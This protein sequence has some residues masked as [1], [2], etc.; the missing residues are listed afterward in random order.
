[1]SDNKIIFS[2][3]Q[4]EVMRLYQDE[5][6]KEIFNRGYEQGKKDA[7]NKFINKFCTCNENPLD[8]PI[9]IF[10]NFKKKELGDEK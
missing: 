3:E 1:M 8:M 7:I 6:R 9:C 5:W 2:H 4:S 10:C